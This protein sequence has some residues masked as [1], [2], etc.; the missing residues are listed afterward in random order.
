MIEL[1]AAAVSG[2]VVGGGVMDWQPID[3]APKDGTR[4]RLGS[5]QCPSSMKAETIHK[6]TGDWVDG[7]WRLSAFFIVPGG[8]MGAL[9]SQ[10]T[11][12]MP[13]PPPPTV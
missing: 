4:V 9:S 7:R 11:H 1:I 5:D 10:P 12:W 6:V 3:S 8:R 13:L 2:A